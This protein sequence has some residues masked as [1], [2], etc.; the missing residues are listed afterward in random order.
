MSKKE[1]YKMD[2]KH[3]RMDNTIEHTGHKGM[4]NWMWYA[5]KVLMYYTI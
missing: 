3:R 1:D 4:Y 5:K 2:Y